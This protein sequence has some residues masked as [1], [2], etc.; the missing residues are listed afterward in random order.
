MVARPRW[1][2]AW[3]R[4]SS[5]I[6][7]PTDDQDPKQA[8]IS[9]SCKSRGS[10]SYVILTCAAHALDSLAAAH[11]ASTPAP[12]S[13]HSDLSR[14]HQCM[15]TA[16][17]PDRRS[18]CPPHLKDKREIEKTFETAVCKPLS[19]NVNKQLPTNWIFPTIRTR[20]FRT[21][22]C[23]PLG[24]P[25]LSSRTT[26]RFPFPRPHLPNCAPMKPMLMSSYFTLFPKGEGRK[27]DKRGNGMGSIETFSSFPCS[28]PQ[29]FCARKFS[30]RKR[31]ALGGL[32]GTGTVVRKDGGVGESRGQRMGKEE[33]IRKKGYGYD[34]GLGTGQKVKERNPL[35]SRLLPFF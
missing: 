4:K 5:P 10:R 30:F 21:R 15:N 34:V 22:Q 28:P 17:E 35:F 7:R 16:Q 9:P 25:F 27:S 18:P 32:R 23:N 1:E 29:I 19:N 13:G 24:R 12:G 2:N 11:P 8:N 3:N 6:N 20:I 14:L 31:W 26:L 33:E